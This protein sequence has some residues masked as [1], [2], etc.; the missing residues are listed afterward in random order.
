[1][2]DLSNTKIKE[3]INM[4]KTILPIVTL[5]LLGGLLM[6]CSSDNNM[7]SPDQVISQ[8]LENSEKIDSYIAESKIVI[9]END[10]IVEENVLK[11][12]RHEDGRV[13]IETLDEAGETI[14]IVVNDGNELIIYDLESEQASVIDDPELIAL[15]QQSPKEQAELSL[16]IVRDTH[17][18]TL[19]DET[20]IA[21]RDVNHLVATPKEKNQLIGKQEIWIDK[22]NWLVL[23]ITSESGDQLIDMMYE[24][25]DFNVDIDD[26]MFSLDLPENVE[27]I[28]LDDIHDVDEVSLTEAADALGQPFLY[29]PEDDSLEISTL[30]KSD[31]QGIVNRI[32]IDIDYKKDDLPY[33]TL[34]IFETPDDVDDMTMP[35]ETE[36]TIRGQDATYIDMKGFRSV[37][38]D[39]D[40]L[41]YS[42]STI[43]PNLSIEDIL[44]LTETM[45]HP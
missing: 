17:D 42:L 41:R 22:E 29:I 20:E 12:W 24:T 14:S 21:G 8:A 23:K 4:R 1:V 19:K 13:R 9:S 28:D 30:E 37:F 38:W 10:Q 26:T 44:E 32:E 11:E 5:I 45:T 7:F 36:T 16:S 43:D 2:R 40:G 27:L 18:L 6:A 25:V 39:E 35:D 33:V 3:G 15:N 34:S 31:L